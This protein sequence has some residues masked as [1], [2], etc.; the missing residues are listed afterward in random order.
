VLNAGTVMLGDR[1]RHLTGDGYELHFQTNYLGHAALT[2]GILPLLEAGRARI[3]VQCSLAARYVSLDRHDLQVKRK[4]TPLR[5]Y[6][7]SK[8]AL[9]LFGTELARHNVARQWN[10]TVHLCHPGIVPG[11]AIAPIISERHSGGLVAAAAQR[12]G[13]SPGQAAQPALMAL[14]TD[15]EPPAMFGPS[16]VG[17][18]SGPA[19]AEKPY[20]SISDWH[21]G[22]RLWDWTR[23]VLPAQPAP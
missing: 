22:S 3:A 1:E 14:T 4:Y 2:L 11:T 10:L 19:A 18:M 13:H 7:S 8:V 9:G 12:L 15:A 20:A 21:A 23:S 6:G 17:H 16:G 5:A